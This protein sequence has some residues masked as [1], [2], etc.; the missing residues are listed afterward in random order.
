M[1]MLYKSYILKVIKNNVSVQG[2]L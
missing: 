2:K 1:Y